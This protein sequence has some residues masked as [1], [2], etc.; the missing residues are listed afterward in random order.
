[1]KKLSD[2]KFWY[3]KPQRINF[4]EFYNIKITEQ[5]LSSIGQTVNPH[6]PDSTVVAC[7][8]AVKF[9]LVVEPHVDITTNRN[10]NQ[11]NY[12]IILHR[13]Y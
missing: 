11:V 3:A 12:N 6:S 5:M 2:S 10:E 1:M 8:Q 13:S 7:V 9:S 4:I